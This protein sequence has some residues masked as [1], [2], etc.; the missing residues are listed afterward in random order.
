MKNVC[1]FAIN[2]STAQLTANSLVVLSSWKKK[3]N[4]SARAWLTTEATTQP[5]PAGTGLVLR[6]LISLFPRTVIWRMNGGIL[7]EIS[8]FHNLNLPGLENFHGCN[9]H[10]PSPAPSLFKWR[11]LWV[12]F[13]CLIASTLFHFPWRN[14]FLPL[15][16]FFFPDFLMYES[17]G[18][19]PNQSYISFHSTYTDGWWYAMHWAKCSEYRI[20]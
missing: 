3:K 17:L 14:H 12:D 1:C 10:L 13:V 15:F 20:K 9:R 19:L 11:S 6:P 5:V 2:I 4:V 18:Y 7:L 8:R 16:M